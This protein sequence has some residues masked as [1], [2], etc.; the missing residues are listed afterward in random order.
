M[1]ERTDAVP[2]SQQPASQQ[3]AD[4][5]PV[6]LQP[7]DPAP[8]FSLPDTDGS[9]VALSDYAGRRVIVYF[10][11]AAGTPGCTAQ[12][13]ELN[14]GAPALA[15]SGYAV[16]GISRDP[17]ATLIGFRERHGIAFP[18]LSDPE[19]VV[20]RAWGAWGEKNSYGRIV[21]GVLRST[22]VVGPEG[23]IELAGY[24]VKATGHLGMLRRRLGL[25]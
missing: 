23:R 6:R 10:Y 25:G 5:Q 9:T 20:H 21:T 24:N 13:C 19:L 16:V 4:L 15:A 17:V 8:A 2:A 1:S 14:E 22:F 11:P 7:G 12:S 18:L 3:P